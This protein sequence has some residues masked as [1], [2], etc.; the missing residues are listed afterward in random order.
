MYNEFGRS[1]S[2]VRALHNVERWEMPLGNTELKKCVLKLF[3]FLNGLQDIENNVSE[4]H[5]ASS[6]RIPTMVSTHCAQM[7]ALLLHIPKGPVFLSTSKNAFAF[8]C[9]ISGFRRRVNEVCALLECYA[10]LIGS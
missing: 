4:E 1:T 2:L 7:V 3:C 8:T 6:F 9:V 10:A 5:A